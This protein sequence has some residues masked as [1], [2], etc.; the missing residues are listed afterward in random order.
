MIAWPDP[1]SE[2]NGRIDDVRSELEK[3]IYDMHTD[4]VNRLD[5]NNA[6]IDRFFETT[7]T[8]YEHGKINERIARLEREVEDLRRQIAA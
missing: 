7:V 5:A 3:R 8:K 1:I 2:T 4:L 6:R